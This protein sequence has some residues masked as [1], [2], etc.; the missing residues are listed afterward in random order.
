MFGMPK[1]LSLKNIVRAVAVVIGVGL[2]VVAS[3]AVAVCVV[4]TLGGCA[5]P[6]IAGIAAIA[7]AGVAISAA[8]IRGTTNNTVT[9]AAATLAVFAAT[10]QDIMSTSSGSGAKTNIVSEPPEPPQ[11]ALNAWEEIKTN[12]YQSLSTGWRVQ[13]YQNTT[14]LLPN[15]TNYTEFYLSPHPNGGVERIVRGDDGS[16]YYTPDHYDTFVR[17]E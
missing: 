15:D 1:W 14:K 7:S 10:A 5:A 13:T 4:A 6:A 11:A 8:G 12:N 3:L 2:L 17:I 9:R 16:V